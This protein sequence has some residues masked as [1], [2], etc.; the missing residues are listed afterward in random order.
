MHYLAL[1]IL[2]TLQNREFRETPCTAHKDTLMILQAHS[3]SLQAPL[4]KSRLHKRDTAAAD[5]GPSLDLDCSL[6]TLHRPS[7]LRHTNKP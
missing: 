1:E 3:K 4:N 5:L 6:S 2:C 7:Q